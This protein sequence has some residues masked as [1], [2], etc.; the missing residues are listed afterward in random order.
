ML[1]RHFEYFTI[2]KWNH[3]FCIYLTQHAMKSKWKKKVLCKNYHKRRNY[4][5]KRKPS[6]NCK[7]SLSR[8]SPFTIL[9]C[10]FCKNVTCFVQNCNLNLAIGIA[11][12]ACVA[13]QRERLH[14]RNVQPD[15]SK[16]FKIILTFSVIFYQIIIVTAFYFSV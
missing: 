15:F 4:K 6:F 1:F 9:F 14:F 2:W 12:L 13:Q 7:A 16:F 8:N 3:S 10:H 5:E 11:G